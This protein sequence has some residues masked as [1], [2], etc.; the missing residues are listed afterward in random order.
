MGRHR[1]VAAAAGGALAAALVLATGGVAS[2]SPP[3]PAA[4]P[5]AGAGAGGGSAA[6]GQQVAGQ[7]GVLG[8]A[9]YKALH[10]GMSEAQ[11]KRTG[12]LVDRQPG[13]C[14]AYYLRP[15]EGKPNPG[16]GVFIGKGRGIVAISGT[17]KIHTP[18]GIGMGSSR[19][20][21]ASAYPKLRPTPTPPDYVY[22]T[23]VPGHSPHKYRF[24][25]VDGSVTD[26][27]LEA[28]NLGSCG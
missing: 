19:G 20:Q 25:I 14:T 22:T 7:A 3:E 16:G 5:R 15:S 13:A 23:S 11:A 4:S 2:A 27:G 8:P 18:E 28:A 1:F 6:A 17:D 12:L 26:F 10:I 21:V 9:G 24:A